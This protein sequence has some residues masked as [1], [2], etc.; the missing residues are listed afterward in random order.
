MKYYADTDRND[1][2]G[3]RDRGDDDSRIGGHGYQPPVIG[4]MPE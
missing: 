1:N 2:H 4:S 3:G